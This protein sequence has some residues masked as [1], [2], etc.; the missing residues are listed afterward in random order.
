[1]EWRHQARTRSRR[2]FSLFYEGAHR[3][4][5]TR[6]R[7]QSMLSKSW[8]TYHSTF[9]RNSAR[10]LQ[11]S[12]YTVPLGYFVAR[13][14]DCA[15]GDIGMAR[16]LSRQSVDSGLKTAT[17]EAN[18]KLKVVATAAS[19]TEKAITWVGKDRALFADPEKKELLSGATRSDLTESIG[20]ALN[21]ILFTTLSQQ[22]LDELALL[23]SERGVVFL[24]EQAFHPDDQVRVFKRLGKTYSGFKASEHALTPGNSNQDS[25]NVWHSDA[26]FEANPPSYSFLN[27]QDTPEFGG[28]AAWVSQYGLYD[29]LSAHMKGF[30]DGLHAVRSSHEQD[31]R[32]TSEHPAVRT[33]PV[34]GL[35]ALNI[36]PGSATG[37][38]ELKQKESGWYL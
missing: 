34:T 29:E 30:L 21:G 18:I 8:D 9:G 36:T 24:R 37:F 6:K 31:G 17:V 3:I 4:F 22:Q 15:H 5:L 14:D 38:A 19:K 10:V 35:K 13:S 11:R 20:T 16:R 1:M 25:R 33:H 26:S 12:E 32:V 7:E 28:D 27:V 2:L 23:V